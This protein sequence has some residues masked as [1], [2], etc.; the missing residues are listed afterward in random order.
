MS[1]HGPLHVAR[2]NCHSTQCAR[3]PRTGGGEATNPQIRD[4]RR[5]RFHSVVRLDPRVKVTL[6]HLPEVGVR[7]SWR[8]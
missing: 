4:T 7:V 3:T 5:I 1:A 8:S 6:A 2:A